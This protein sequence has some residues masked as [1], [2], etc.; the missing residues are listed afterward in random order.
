MNFSEVKALKIP[1]GNVI[2]IEEG[3]SILFEINKGPVCN[4]I[5][6]VQTYTGYE[7]DSLTVECNISGIDSS[8]INNFVDK[9][10]CAILIKKAASLSNPDDLTFDT[11]GRINVHFTAIDGDTITGGYT[12]FSFKPLTTTLSSLKGYL[13]TYYYFRGYI[14]YTDKDGNVIDLYSEPIKASYNS[15]PSISIT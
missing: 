11:P 9:Y 10:K 8:F 14:N 7:E 6:S 15:S 12:R 3:G 5:I 1:E 2:K 13:T 4:P